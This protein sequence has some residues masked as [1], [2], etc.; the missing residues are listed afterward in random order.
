MG[1]NQVKN[2][3]SDGLETKGLVGGAPDL[4]AKAR[5]VKEVSHPFFWCPLESADHAAALHAFTGPGP[6]AVEIGFGRGYFLGRFAQLHS[7]WNCLGLEV[8]RKLIREALVRLDRWGVESARLLLGDARALLPRF[9]PPASIEALFIL[10]PDPW[11]K[12]KHHKRRLLDASGLAPFVPLLKDGALVVV[13]SDVPLVL[14]LARAALPAIGCKPLDGPGLELPQ[15]DRERVCDRI[16]IPS[17]ELCYRFSSE[18]V[19]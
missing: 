2:V 10:F 16:G 3:R 18:D 19:S 4:R 13:R 8:K 1:C 9:L 6:L 17:Q 5:Q 7:D 14:D 11:W 12:K 15:T